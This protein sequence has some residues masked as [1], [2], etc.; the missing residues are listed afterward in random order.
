VLAPARFDY[1]GSRRRVFG[2]ERGYRSPIADIGVRLS[3]TEPGKAARGNRSSLLLIFAAGVTLLADD[4]M[5]A[6]ISGPVFL[7]TL[8][9]SDL[10][11]AIAAV[12][13]R[14]DS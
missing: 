9:H 13:G 11:G 8:Q 5:P 7:Q 14:Q 2:S 10:S 12:Q 4:E 1:L 6:A 3:G